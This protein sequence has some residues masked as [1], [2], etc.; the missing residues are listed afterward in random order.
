MFKLSPSRDPRLYESFSRFRWPY[1]LQ[2]S[3][4][5]WPV[6]R[7]YCQKNLRFVENYSLKPLL[8]DINCFREITEL[9]IKRTAFKKFRHFAP[10]NVRLSIV[11]GGIKFREDVLQNLIKPPYTLRSYSG[12]YCYEYF[13]SPFQVTKNTSVNSNGIDQICRFIQFFSSLLF[14][15]ITFAIISN[16]KSGLVYF[17]SSSLLRYIRRLSLHNYLPFSINSNIGKE[18]LE[19]SSFFNKFVA[20]CTNNVTK[21]SWN[22]VCDNNQKKLVGI[23]KVCDFNFDCIDQSDEVFWCNTF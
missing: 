20:M 15:N 11:V 23:N 6:S 21:C 3:V 19:S 12:N 8:N 17:N 10:S 13:E 7:G 4:T 18:N 1:V 9:N 14:D 5:T 2:V 16:N 22:F